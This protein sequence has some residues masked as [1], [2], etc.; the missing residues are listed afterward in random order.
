[1]YIT[2]QESEKRQVGGEDR[3]GVFLEERTERKHRERDGL[4]IDKDAGDGAV[5]ACEGAQA[6]ACNHNRRSV[7]APEK[8]TMLKC[9]DRSTYP[10]L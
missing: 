7:C 4:E 1:M 2:E 6:L 10:T 5:V 8:G 3:G 9:S